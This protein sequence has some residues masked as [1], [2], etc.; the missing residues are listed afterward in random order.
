MAVSRTER[1]AFLWRLVPRVK[2]AVAASLGKTAT[3][4]EIL[5]I[6]EAALSAGTARVAVSADGGL[7]DPTGSEPFDA[8]NQ[9]YIQDIRRHP[10]EPIV[11]L[12]IS[13]GDPNTAP[14]A[15]LDMTSA[16]A[17]IR[18]ENPKPPEAQGWSAHL[19]ISTTMISGSHRGCYERM[20]GV[21]ASLM[22]A[23]LDHIVFA[24]LAKNPTYEFE[25]SKRVKSKLFIDRKPY[26]PFLDVGPVPSERL[27]DD[28][29]QGE[30][31]RITLTRSVTSYA[32]PAAK[33]NVVR[34]ERK[35]ILHTA[36]S[37]APDIESL[38]QEVMVFAREKKYE[39]ITFNLEKLPGNM[40]NQPTIDITEEDA[41]EVLYVRAQRLH[42]F[43]NLLE[44][45]Y[46][47]VSPQIEEKMIEVITDA[48]LW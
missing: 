27:I 19:C 5:C 11:T 9:I 34:Q 28:L 46:S 14:P 10:T 8:K 1:R 18:V 33:K 12:L 31:S 36:K 17:P 42:G 3:L 21:S 13:R 43:V 30:L 37:N 24:A 6:L 44:N 35:L 47:K 26:R 20:P 4:E 41:L 40:T 15:F 29:K 38:V 25:T 48:A 16:S 22:Q 23:A 39:K 7:W 2:P 32:G 45:A